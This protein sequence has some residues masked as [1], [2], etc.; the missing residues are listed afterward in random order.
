MS[1]LLQLPQELL[2]LLFLLLPQ[3]AL[4]RFSQTCHLAYDLSSPTLYSHVRVGF[5]AHV[6]QLEQG[7]KKRPKLKEL[8]ET[9]TRT[10]TLK[11]HTS[12]N[13]WFARDFAGLLTATCNVRVL[14]LSDFDALSIDYLSR[15][16]AALPNIECLELHYCNLTHE[17]LPTTPTASATPTTL[18]TFPL[19]S[20]SSSS[21]ASVSGTTTS[22]KNNNTALFS[23]TRRLNFCWTDFSEEAVTSLLQKLPYLSSVDLGANRNR[24]VGA[25]TA[26]VKSLQEHC[27]HIKEL[28]ISLQQVSESVLCDTIA[29]YGPQLHKLSIRCDGRETLKSVAQHATHVKNLTIRAAGTTTIT[30]TTTAAAPNITTTTVSNMNHS[31]NPSH[32]TVQQQNQRPSSVNASSLTT[33]TIHHNTTNRVRGSPPTLSSSLSQLP[34]TT[35]IRNNNNNNIN[36]MN[37]RQQQHQPWI[38]M[39]QGN[40]VDQQQQQQEEEED[41]GS[42]VGILQR[43]KELVHLEMVSWMVQDVPTVVWRGIDAVASRRRRSGPTSLLMH[44][45][46]LSNKTLALDLEE[47]QE[48]RKQFVQ[49]HLLA[50]HITTTAT[51]TALHH[52]HHHHHHHLHA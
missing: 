48:I 50:D 6:R 15:L 23:N 29:H 52:H 18:Y 22:D 39:Q 1:L 43:C 34:S 17:P 16:A 5:R 44:K 37:I 41:H 51:T 4:A 25:N 2:Q 12:S 24:V 42:I 13:L 40:G 49:S 21:L 45:K 10:L 30:T 8:L 46:M 19:S 14:T 20:P 11:N 31:N 26:A 32:T 38:M 27:I 3:Q 7:I 36:A 9:Y 28:T 33:T 35:V 47:L